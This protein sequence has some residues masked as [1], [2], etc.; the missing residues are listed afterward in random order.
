MDVGLPIPRLPRKV[1]GWV[2]A[3]ILD[4][5][6][7]PFGERL[8]ES[9]SAEE[10]KARVVELGNQI[11]L[12]DAKKAVED[13]KTYCEWIRDFSPWDVGA[14][15]PSCPMGKLSRRADSK[16][17]VLAKAWTKAG[18][19]FTLEEEEQM[20][21]S[22][23]NRLIGESGH[24]LESKCAALDTS[25]ETVGGT[26]GSF[27]DDPKIVQCLQS[28]VKGAIARIAMGDSVRTVALEVARSSPEIKRH[29]F[30]SFFVPTVVFMS[31]QWGTWLDM[32]CSSIEEDS[33]SFDHGVSSSDDKKEKSS[34]ED[35]KEQLKDD[36][37]EVIGATESIVESEL[38]QIDPQLIYEESPRAKQLRKEITSWMQKD[39]ENKMIQFKRAHVDAKFG[40]FARDVFSEN[41]VV[42][43]DGTVEVCK[44]LSEVEA[45]W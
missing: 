20:E 40:D 27:F 5:P 1:L 30:G 38:G 25:K 17:S 24:T 18:G 44:R 28:H 34:V 32:L 33:P 45:L 41:C 35:K 11:L 42:L 10:E 14:R 23:R 43:E 21:A 39:L 9:P 31:E 13:G 26:I 29:P 16:R 37:N 8:S 4:P 19:S 36:E 15:T 22:E 3:L 6:A 7:A 12:A 2:Q